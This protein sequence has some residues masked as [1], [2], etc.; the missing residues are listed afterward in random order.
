LFQQKSD[1][2]FEHVDTKNQL[3]VIFTKP[4]APKPFFNIRGELR[5]LDAAS[6]A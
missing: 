1:V 4:L 5:I 3:A 2:V 6:L